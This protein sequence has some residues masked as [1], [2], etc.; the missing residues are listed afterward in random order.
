M[1]LK[2]GCGCPLLILT[3]V[4][5]LLTGA[6]LFSVIR[7]PGSEPVQGS[8][9]GIA[10]FLLLFAANTIGVGLFALATWRRPS[11][12]PSGDDTSG[13]TYSEGEESEGGAESSEADGEEED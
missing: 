8:R 4:N 10:I 9:G 7:G 11:E 6:A 2:R 12:E 1:R 3:L 5:L 13:A